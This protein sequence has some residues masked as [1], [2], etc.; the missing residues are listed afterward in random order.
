MKIPLA[1]A[2]RQVQTNSIVKIALFG[3][4]SSLKMNS[5][6]CQTHTNKRS[7]HHLFFL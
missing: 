3:V 1:F 4:D 5:E 7:S 2:G 6:F